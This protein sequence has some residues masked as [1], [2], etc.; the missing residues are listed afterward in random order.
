VPDKLVML[1]RVLHEQIHQPGLKDSKFRVGDP[2]IPWDLL[3]Q[4]RA[5][6]VLETADKA[7]RVIPLGFVRGRFRCAQAWA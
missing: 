6:R 2:P 4:G 1:S 7:H 3:S 5:Y